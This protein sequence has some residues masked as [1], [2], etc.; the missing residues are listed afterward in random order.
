MP[1]RKSY[2]APP[3]KPLNYGPELP[4][5][6]AAMDRGL[7]DLLQSQQL[8][9]FDVSLHLH[10]TQVTA[11]LWHPSGQWFLPR[12]ITCRNGREEVMIERL[13]VDDR[14][15]LTE[16]DAAIFNLGHLIPRFMPAFGPPRP[17]ILDL[18][19]LHPM[20]SPTLSL[21]FWGEFAPTPW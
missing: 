3:P 1:Y 14:V 21:T 20:E 10:S 12:G 2:P 19:R 15:E 17:A 5:E 6:D 8:A 11:E 9:P 7:R 13:V 18:R 4:L 16:V